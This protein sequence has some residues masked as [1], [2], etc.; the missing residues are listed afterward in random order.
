M[1]AHLFDPRPVI[2]PAQSDRDRAY[3]RSI[4]AKESDREAERRRRAKRDA[5][6]L[7]AAEKR[8][9]A[10]L[11]SRDVGAELIHKQEV[12]R[13]HLDAA[14][15]AA[16]ERYWRDAYAVSARIK[17]MPPHDRSDARVKIARPL[18]DSGWSLGECAKFV[19]VTKT[20]M[21]RDVNPGYLARQV[22]ARKL[23]RRQRRDGLTEPS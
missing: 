23:W 19:G 21:I 9:A 11:N 1:T 8:A 16:I 7:A 18:L 10:K 20:A 14:E 12:I 17:A 2:S 5:S 4:R 15:C 22:E 3:F 13:E 6:R